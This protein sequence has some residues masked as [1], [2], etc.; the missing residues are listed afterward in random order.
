MEKFTKPLPQTTP[1]AKEYWEGCKKHKLLIQKCKDCGTFRHYP[2]VLCPKCISWNYDWTK[3]SGKGK[4]YTWTVAV[5]P[6]HPA[7]VDE[8]PYAVIIVELDEGIRIVSNLKEAKPE[9]I[10]IGMPVEVIFESITEDVTLPQF[11]PIR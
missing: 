6:F 4:I 8:A 10:Y 11:K 2:R 5:Q 9:D 7:F 1:E 3:V